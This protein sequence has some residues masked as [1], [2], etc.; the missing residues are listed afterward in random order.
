M[1]RR[2]MQKAEMVSSCSPVSPLPL[3]HSSGANRVASVQFGFGFFQRFH[4]VK[5]GAFQFIVLLFQA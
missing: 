5:Q 3:C 4:G 2:L 1:V